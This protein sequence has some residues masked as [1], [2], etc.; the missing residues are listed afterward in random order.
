MHLADI[1]YADSSPTRR[2]RTLRTYT[3]AS[4]FSVGLTQTPKGFTR[5]QGAQRIWDTV[6]CPTHM[7]ANSAD[8]LSRARSRYDHVAMQHIWIDRQIIDGGRFRLIPDRAVVLDD[9]GAFWSSAA[10]TTIET[11][12]A[13][14]RSRS[15]ASPV[16]HR[17]CDVQVA[18]PVSPSHNWVIR[19]VAAI[20]TLTLTGSVDLGP[21][22]QPLVWNAPSGV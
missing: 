6:E 11:C 21:G 20:A 12:A 7:A 2:L 3:D 13:V 8:G 4:W 1:M 17:T 19:W 16:A 5:L 10:P 22:L 14:P 18:P 15:A 9:A